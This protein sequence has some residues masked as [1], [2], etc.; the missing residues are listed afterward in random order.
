[1]KER[2]QDKKIKKLGHGCV[3]VMSFLLS[4]ALA[5]SLGVIQVNAQDFGAP[6]CPGS[7][8][9]TNRIHGYGGGTGYAVTYL[10]QCDWVVINTNSWIT[11]T[12]P[13]NGGPFGSA[14]TLTYD[15]ALNPTLQPRS[16]N[17]TI[18]GHNLS[19][20]Q[21]GFSCDYF[22]SPGGVDHGYGA[23]EGTIYVGT[24]E[25]CPWNVVNTN[26]WIT[27]LSGDGGGGVG[28]IVYLVDAN[29][30]SESRSG[31]ITIE[32]R[33]FTL[34]QEGHLAVSLPADQI[35]ALG[36]T[37]TFSVTV[38][39][40]NVT[41]P[42]TYQWEFNGANLIDGGGI[43]GA[44][45]ANLVL[46]G[47]QYSQG[48]HYLCVVSNAFG[49]PY[50]SSSATLTVAPTSNALS[51]AEAVDTGDMFFWKTW[52]NSRGIWF[53]QTNTAYDGFD[54]LE[55]SGLA[56]GEFA[57]LETKSGGPGLLSFWWKSDFA[58]SS[59]ALL[60]WIGDSQLASL[61]TTTDWEQ[62]TFKVPPG[63]V[64]LRWTFSNA[65]SEESK[66]W[67][68][69]VNF[70]PCDF[71]L[72][73][74][75]NYPSASSWGS[76]GAVTV[77]AA[78]DCAWNV[79]NTN[80]WITILS[81]VINN[82]SGVV[83]YALA[84]NP[85]PVIR[86]G[87][88]IIADQLYSISQYPG[89]PTNS[90]VISLPEALDTEGSLAWSTIGTPEWF[91]QRIFSR[92]GVDAAQSGP[93]GDSGAVT[94][95]TT[96]NGPGTILFWWRVS[97]ETNKDYL[98]FFIN[99]VQQSRISGEV[100]WQLARY[101][102]TSVTNT[103]KWTY[104]KNNDGAVGQDRGWL[105]QVQF[106]P[107]SET[108]NCVR[109]ISPASVT[110]TGN[111]ETGSV[112]VITTAAC[113]WDAVNTNSWITYVANPGE[114]TGLVR[115][116]VSANNSRISRSG[117]MLIGG[118]PFTVTQ[119][120]AI[121]PCSYSLSSTYAG[122]DHVPSTGYVV[123]VTTQADCD[124]NVIT[125]NDWITITSSPTNLENGLVTYSVSQNNAAVARTGQILIAGQIYTVWQ[126]AAPGPTLAAALDTDGTP[127]N[128]T[129]ASAGPWF[130]QW[131]VTHDGV[132]A[133]QSGPIPGLGDGYL[134][135]RVTG[136][137]TLSFWW[138]IS[139]NTNSILAFTVGGLVL[140]RIIGEVDWQQQ[141]VTIT[142]GIK[143][144]GWDYV[145]YF[146]RSPGQNA[147][148]VDQVQFVPTPICPIALSAFN[149]SHPSGSS[150]GLI[151]VAAAPDCAWYVSSTNSWLSI[152]SGTNGL[153]NG[154][155]QYRVTPN[156]GALQRF[157]Y[158]WI[159]DRT[160]LVIQSGGGANQPDCAISL[161]PTNRIHGY[162]SATNTVLVT[163]QAGCAWN[164][165]TSNWWIN[166][167]SPSLAS[168]NSG[169]VAYSLASNTNTQPRGGTILIGG[170][171]FLLTQLGAPLSE[172]NA[173]QLQLLGQT[174]TNTTLFV[175]GT[176][177][178]MYVVECS[179]DLIHWTPIVTNASASSATDVLTGNAPRRFYRTVE[180]H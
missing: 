77:T 26:S 179:E 125:T 143:D 19:L 93:V 163:A 65:A 69:Q 43:S 46:T 171:R 150:T 113:A 38:N 1:M 49:S 127:L 10:L 104:S 105:D 110:H 112:Y 166:I 23:A 135:T 115:Y 138:K 94:T 157:G 15:V 48:G 66:A 40:T 2:L 153:G 119:S 180:S 98:K 42:V 147:A 137:G 101:D 140:T 80:S 85:T 148:W 168:S 24:A 174:V 107:A 170:Q 21:K 82:G 41:P 102:L 63:N 9:P 120:G 64:D 111:S 30:G 71:H 58:T 103:L 141:S 90:P 60:F 123:I 155:V 75:Y 88:L 134:T 28:E 36:G 50:F 152:L 78:A 100:D 11:I 114:S 27:I 33:I 87:Y 160:F 91:G 86:Y 61:T 25:N 59:D 169:V 54:A 167:I 5:N 62:H 29:P 14:Q 129:T 133:A 126:D 142:P 89:L 3:L 53:G 118:R 12:S 17:I 108:D 106:I 55:C 13:T 130:G 4:M 178:K 44:T 51:I 136:P 177:G 172:T 95:A 122:Y 165:F 145:Q 84:G 35:V 18:G 156:S 97:S 146:P 158:I 37:A 73:S 45:T 70:I 7:I 72:S 68:D 6:V 173:P 74:S 116:T 31:N 22:I 16:G 8:S 164:V 144:L 161:S 128:W 149:A 32:W 175:Q 20:T 76:T 83:T 154:S 139:S 159:A 99:G 121:P 92:D 124:W 132:D 79:V 39:F 57:S 67:L 81:S 176:Q 109:A 151:N 162:A 47:V 34:R 117:V 56:A 96:M 131:D 52:S